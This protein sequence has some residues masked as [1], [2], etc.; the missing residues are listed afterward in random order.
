MSLETFSTRSV[1]RVQTRRDRRAVLKI[2]KAIYQQ[3][4]GWV[5]GVEEVFPS[6]ELKEENVSWFV[7]FEDKQPIGVLRVLYTPPIEVYKQY[8]MEMNLALDLETFLSQHKIA[9]IGRFAILPSHRTRMTFA[10]LLIQAA[11]SETVLRGYSHFIT[12]VFE[13]EPHSPYKFHTRVLGFEPV[14]SHAHGELK[15][16]HRRITLLLNLKKAYQRLKA[17][18]NRVYRFLKDGWEDRIHHAL[19]V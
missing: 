18:N 6:T 9:E 1:R 10:L 12:D 4:K 3:E 19:A 13:D 7:A 2:L 17:E 16:H 11:T 14:A 5:D 15:T 8:A